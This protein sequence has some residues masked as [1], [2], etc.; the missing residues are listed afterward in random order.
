MVTCWANGYL[1]RQRRYVVD[2]R[3]FRAAILLA[4][5]MWSGFGVVGVASAAGGTCTQNAPGVSIDNNWAWSAPGSWGMPG[6]QLGYAI[7]VRNYDVGCSSSS[8]VVSMSAPS[9]FSVSIPTSTVSLKASSSAYLWAY[10]TSPAGIA[11]GDYPLTATVQRVGTATASAPYISYYKVYSSDGVAPTLF[12]ANPA[13]GATISGRSYN[14]VVSSSDDHAVKSI[15]LYIDGAYR[16][17]TTCDDVSYICQLSYK[18]SLRGV[19]G[20]HTA[21]FRSYDWMGNEGVQMVSFA[22][23]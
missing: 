9:G 8:F 1:L 11:D 2:M 4:L 16:A 19:Q 17:T 5:L 13:D 15:D 22:V 6:Q 20:Q 3:H 23:S 10:V 7:Q 18:W 12:W 14:V 21:T